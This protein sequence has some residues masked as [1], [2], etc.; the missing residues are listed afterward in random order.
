[1][2]EA[3]R[4]PPR[5]ARSLWVRGEMLGTPGHRESR[6]DHSGTAPRVHLGGRRLERERKKR[7]R[8]PSAREGV[9]RR[10]RALPVA[11]PALRL[12]AARPGEADVCAKRSSAWF[13]AARA[14]GE[15]NAATHTTDCH[16][17][18]TGRSGGHAARPPSSGVSGCGRLETSRLAS[19][20]AWGSGESRSSGG[21]WARDCLK[22]RP[23]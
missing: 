5:K 22:I 20:G 7:G 1:M 17:A 13:A 18:A 21:C 9:S 16:P 15:P 23:W 2:G 3:G 19:G 6:P 12:P 4:T 11:A 8:R 14:G 10:D